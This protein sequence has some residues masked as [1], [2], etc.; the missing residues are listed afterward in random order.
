MRIKRFQAEVMTID[1][2]NFHNIK[3][4]CV[5]VIRV[6]SLSFFCYYYK[7]HRKFIVY[8]TV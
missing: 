3:D 7:N 4:V 1:K 6:V 2:L 5:C 8:E